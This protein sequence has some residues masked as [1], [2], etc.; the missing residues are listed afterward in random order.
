M[1]LQSCLR[2]VRISYH[3]NLKAQWNFEAFGSFPERQAEEIAGRKCLFSAL[4]FGQVDQLK[5]NN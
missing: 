5:G 3:L 4:D 1:V 2:F